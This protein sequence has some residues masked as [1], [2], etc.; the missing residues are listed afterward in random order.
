MVL[1]NEKK[2]KLLGVPLTNIP[3]E[4]F[5]S[6]I[7]REVQSIEAKKA[8]FLDF[9]G[10]MRERRLL[11][12]NKP[13]FINKAN[14]V[15]TTSAT[16]AKAAKK[17]YGAEHVRFYPFYLVVRILGI[18]EKRNY[19][20]YFL[21][22]NSPEI[23]KLT[24]HVR[25]TFEGVKIVG[26]YKG[27][28]VKSE[29][30]SVLMGIKKAGANFLLVGSRI[31]NPEKWI[32]NN[33]DKFQGL[34]LVAPDAFDVMSAKNKPKNVDDWNRKKTT[35]FLSLLLP[36]KWLLALSYLKFEILVGIEK[37]RLKKLK[38]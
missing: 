11:K 20:A 27:N 17:L 25:S 3:E 14:L 15:F 33:G 2:I 26:R 13:S 30:E 29:E 4:D 31:K 6:V 1:G 24:A 38:K 18:L 22:G 5:E 21:G 36:W 35:S 16:V 8:V 23:M 10:F 9:K 37:M 34:S 19:S 7:L 32:V 12:R 28:Y